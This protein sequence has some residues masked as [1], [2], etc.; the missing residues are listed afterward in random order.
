[1]R[2]NCD[3]KPVLP[4]DK[5]LTDVDRFTYLGSVMSKDEDCSIDIKNR[6]G[7]H[8]KKDQNKN[9]NSNDIPVCLCCSEIWKTTP[10]NGIE[11]SKFPDKMP[12][13]TS[14]HQME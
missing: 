12:V 1:M 3:R 4:N 5:A 10:K 6:H 7:E 11:T 14:K 2:V 8:F 9:F 13:Q